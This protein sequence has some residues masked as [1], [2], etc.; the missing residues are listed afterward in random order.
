MHSKQ[1]TRHRC[2]VASAVVALAACSAV[3]QAQS[4]K[5]SIGVRETLTTAAIGTNG[6][7]GGGTANSIEWV[8]KDVQSVTAG[9]DWQTFTFTFGTDPTTYFAGTTPAGGSD[10]HLDYSAA[11][12]GGKGVLEHMR[13]LNSGGIT[14]PIALYIDDVINTPVGGAPVTLDNFDSYPA[15]AT[16]TANGPNH[17]F[18]NPRFSGSTQ[19]FVTAGSDTANVSADFAASAPNSYR[20][21]WRYV[22]G[23]TAGWIRDT[24]SGFNPTIDIRPGSTLTF[25]AKL[26]VIPVAEGWNVDADGNWNDTANWVAGKVPN[27]INAIARFGYSTVPITAPRTITLDGNVTAGGLAF[28]S[29]IPY[30]VNSIDANTGI[31]LRASSGFDLLLSSE[32]GSHTINAGMEAQARVNLNVVNA[33]D[34]L[35]ITNLITFDYTLG[36]TAAGTNYRKLTDM[37]KN[38]AGKAVV[39]PLAMN[40]VNVAAGILSLNDTGGGVTQLNQLVIAGTAA[41][42]T[43]KFDIGTNGVVLDYGTSAVNTVNPP[44]VTPPTPTV[45]AFST[46]RS[47]IIAAYDAG[48]W[49]GNGI[50]SHDIAAGKGI[51]YAETTALGITPA[52]GMFMGT[53]VDD[54][55]VVIRL[56]YLGDANLDG[57]VNFT[58]LVALAQN[59]NASYDPNGPDGP[60]VWTQGDFNYNG[61]ADFNDLVPLAQNYNKSL[62][63]AEAATLGADFA[64]DYALALQL[65]PEPTTLAA[66]GAATTLLIRRRR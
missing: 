58:D 53:A 12:D 61:I 16:P 1:V 38:G 65:V 25:K 37:V 47:R 41:A 21:G 22:D 51:G 66:V 14:D 30:T 39:N 60:K 59:Y 20:L 42:P 18:Q 64:Q 46:Q 9:Q 34:T 27:A 24:T 15:L 35:T 62:S 5:L 40:T 6:N 50:N 3:A 52:G 7:L 54:S 31:A 33:T 57:T 2:A 36:G 13:I 28:K 56:T 17:I 19:T 49:D 10:N 45:T 11:A 23:N 63:V 29:A 55:A 48:A 4:L 32:L 26:V 43:A 8:N 44:P